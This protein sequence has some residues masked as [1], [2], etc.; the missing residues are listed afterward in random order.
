MET[1][2][3]LTA[4][5][6]EAVRG[7]L[8]LSPRARARIVSVHCI[9]LQNWKKKPSA[10]YSIRLVNPYQQQELLINALQLPDK[11]FLL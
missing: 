10:G 5:E 8:D 4:M 9:I 6:K 7:L 3:N 11:Q 2:Y 1:K